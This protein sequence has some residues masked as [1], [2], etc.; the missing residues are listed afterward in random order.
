M[1]RRA[2]RTLRQISLS[3]ELGFHPSDV[4]TLCETDF[5]GN[6]SGSYGRS[7]PNVPGDYSILGEHE[8]KP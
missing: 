2:R 8:P 3:G 6:F 1:G 7:E 4:T 5:H